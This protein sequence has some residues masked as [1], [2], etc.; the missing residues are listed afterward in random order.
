MHTVP[1]NSLRERRGRII[2]TFVV[3]LEGWLVYWVNNNCA[4]RNVL[5]TAFQIVRSSLAHVCKQT[6]IHVPAQEFGRERE[7]RS[8]SLFHPLVDVFFFSVITV[9]IFLCGCFLLGCST[10]QVP[11]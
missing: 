7:N 3:Y 5:L 4:I 2:I 9:S 1:Q 11:W 10:L 6:F 8:N